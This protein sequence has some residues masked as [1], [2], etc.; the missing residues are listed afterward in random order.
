M[1]WE[2][3]LNDADDD[4]FGDRGQL[5]EFETDWTQGWKLGPEYYFYLRAM[6]LEK[7][8]DDFLNTL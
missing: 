7:A 8:A 1:A 2:P 3:A 4:D 6:P 5:D